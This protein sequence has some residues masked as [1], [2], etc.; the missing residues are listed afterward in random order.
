VYKYD[1]NDYLIE[2]QNLDAD[3][4]ITYKSTY[5]YDAKGNLFHKTDFNGNQIELIREFHYEYFE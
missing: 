2:K 5:L 1:S 3:Q 4:N